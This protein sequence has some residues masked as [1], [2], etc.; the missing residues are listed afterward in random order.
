MSKN[1]TNTAA[2]DK[3]VSR[4]VKDEQKRVKTIV[5]NALDAAKGLEDKAEKKAVTGALKSLQAEL[6][7]PIAG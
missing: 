1:E 4:A 3:A 7:S 2:I 6:A 5:K